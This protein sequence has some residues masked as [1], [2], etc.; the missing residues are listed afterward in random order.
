M[1]DARSWLFP[2]TS[3]E[4]ILKARPLAMA[5][6]ERL[7]INP[8]K[9]LHGSVGEALREAGVAWEAV[10]EGLRDLPPPSSDADWR[11]LPVYHLLDHLT[12][13]H[14]EFLHGFIPAVGRVLSDIPDSD[15]VSLQRL[16]AFSAE[17]PA[18]AST[19]ARHLQEEEEVLFLRILRYDS[20]LRLESTGPDFE[21]GSVRVFT[22]VRML[23]REHRDVALLRRFLEKAAPDFPGRGE[24]NLDQRLFPLLADFQG[25]LARYAGLET[26]VLVPWGIELEKYLYDL[27]IRGSAMPGAR[28]SSR[29][30]LE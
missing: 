19:L 14:R 25:T 9:A 26:D 17:W 30:T 5:L 24:S 6:F 11:S 3:M 29:A 10:L 8:W 12:G 20:C 15:A 4:T 23:E 7:G 2:D 27:H 18:F 13:L 28:V 16:Q 1:L 22:V 21:G